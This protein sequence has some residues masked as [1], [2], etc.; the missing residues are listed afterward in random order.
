MK[1][2]VMEMDEPKGKYGSY[3]DYE[4]EHLADKYVEVAECKQDSK[5]HAAVMKCLSKKKKAINSLDDIR[6]RANSM[7][8]ED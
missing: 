8:D 5:K 2:K 1:G 3:P 6:E 7:K 4:I